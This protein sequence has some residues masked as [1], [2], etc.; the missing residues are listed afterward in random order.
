M[1]IIPGFLLKKIYRNGSLRETN[2]GIL[3][4][5][6]NILGP[7]SITGIN[8]IKINDII[9]ESPMIKILTAGVSILAEHIT[10]DNP[11]FF[12]LNQEGTCFLNGAK[13]LKNGLNK[14][15]I[16]LVSRDAGMVQVTLTDTI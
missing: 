1:T 6:K 14:I 8:F 10:P 16:E 4:E 9:Y 13:G 7:G 12:K 2:D 11:V 15:I 5:L 3:F